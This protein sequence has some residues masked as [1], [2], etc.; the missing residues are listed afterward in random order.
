[1]KVKRYGELAAAVYHVGHVVAD[2]MGVRPRASEGVIETKSR[3]INDVKWVHLRYLPT[4]S[5]EISLRHDGAWLST[6]RN[7][8][9]GTLRWRAVFP[10]THRTLLVNGRE[11]AASLRNA[12]GEGPESWV[13]VNVGPGEEVVVRGE[14]RG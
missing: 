4:L 2:L 13:E 9:G 7:D 11:R 3:L 14:E 10:G 6:L 5:N 1:M 8:R 12:P